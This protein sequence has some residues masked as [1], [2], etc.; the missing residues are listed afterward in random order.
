MASGTSN[1]SAHSVK[2]S[3]LKDAATLVGLTGGIGSGKSAI[4]ER[5]ASYGASIVDSDVIAHQITCAGGSAIEPIRECFGSEFIQADGAL[6]RK[7]MRVLVFEDPHS[8]KALEAITHPLIRTKAI[9]Q[10]RLA[11]ENQAPYIVFV[12][13]LLLESSDWLQFIDHVVVA[14]C[15]EAMQIQRVMERNDLT[16]QEVESI[17]QAQATRTE[18][19]AQADTVVKNMGSLEDLAEQVRL[20]HQKILQIRKS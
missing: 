5:L 20:L 7:K 14:D 18:R 2:L 8:R 10:A 11:V 16:R 9:E 1:P 19:L 3:T 15:S 13:P 4:A 12:V 17:L 6:N